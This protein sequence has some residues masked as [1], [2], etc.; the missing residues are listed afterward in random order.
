MGIGGVGRFKESVEKRPVKASEHLARCLNRPLVYQEGINYGLMQTAAA[1]DKTWF[2]C[3]KYTILQ[4][5]CK[6]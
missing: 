6:Q 3:Y 2:N 5:V 1:S 4:S